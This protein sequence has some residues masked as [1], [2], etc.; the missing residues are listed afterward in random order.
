MHHQIVFLVLISRK[1]F[2]ENKVAGGSLR[3]DEEKWGNRGHHK[4]QFL[5][6]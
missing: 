6:F 4:N 2:V 1:R 5:A 3:V